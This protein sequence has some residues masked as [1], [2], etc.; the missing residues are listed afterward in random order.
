MKTLVFKTSL[1]NLE[2]DQG[3]LEINGS[4]SHIEGHFKDSMLVFRL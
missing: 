1:T 2:L 4:H 3:V